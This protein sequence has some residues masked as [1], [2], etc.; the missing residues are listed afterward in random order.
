MQ[1]E[2]D[3]LLKALCNGQLESPAKTADEVVQFFH[4]P[5]TNFPFP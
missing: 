1:K 3:Y 5:P 4:P 2:N